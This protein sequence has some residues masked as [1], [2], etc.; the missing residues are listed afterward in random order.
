MD[1]IEIE[2]TSRH[3]ALCSDIVVRQRKQIRLIFRPEMVDNPQNPAA[4]IRGRFLY[5]RKGREDSWEEF[6]TKPLSS[7]KKG[8]QFQLEIKAGELLPL[9]RGLGALYRM[10][11]AHGVPQGR[12]K[13]LKIESNLAKF[14]QLSEPEL[15]EFLSAN[16]TEALK[17]L[18]RV[19]RWLSRRPDAAGLL[20]SEEAELSE[21]SALVGLT[22]L[23]AVLKIWSENPKNE[24]EEF[25]QNVL[26]KHS[27]V[28]SQILAYPV[29]VV[30]GRAYV[31]GKRIN[32]LHGNLVDFLGHVSTTRAA[33]LIE[34][35]NPTTPLLGTVYR[36]DVFPPSRDLGGALSQVL[37]YRESLMHEIH[38]LTR[39]GASTISGSEPRCVIIAGC[40]TRE[41]T[42]EA[43]KRSFERFR[44]RLVGVTVLTF[45]ELFDRVKGLVDLFER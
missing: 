3:S 11:R 29:I 13:F 38:T 1:R 5:Q 34:I 22:N 30:K 17:S 14:L 35:K 26:T 32:N 4:C 20:A 8:D 44:E 28:L 45:D 6:D 7:L 19:V 24:S 42:D 16:T 41:L 12:V 43:R 25:W 31:G 9:L 39:D 2:S 37:A 40:A 21:L 27:F 15:S 23:R 33:V 10:Y 36:Q 18:G